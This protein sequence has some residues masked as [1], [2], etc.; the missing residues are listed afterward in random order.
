VQRWTADGKPSGEPVLVSSSGVS[1]LSFVGD[2]THFATA[3]GDGS[4][5]LWSTSTLQQFG[6]DLPKGPGAGNARYS[7][8][9]NTLV[10]VY[11]DGSG[12]V[13]PV[14]TEAWQQHACSVAGRNFTR[15]EWRRY[16]TGLDFSTVCR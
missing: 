3:G 1:S 10:V 9:G 6:S 5:K 4:V 7:P 13:W 11:D 8:D 16:V 14:S 15:E 12:V 2:G